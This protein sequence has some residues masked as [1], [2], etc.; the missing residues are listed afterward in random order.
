MT[1]RLANVGSS[2]VAVILVPANQIPERY[3]LRYLL[4]VLVLSYLL[5]I[6]A[7]SYAHCIHKLLFVWR[8][9][10]IATKTLGK[11]QRTLRKRK[12][13]S[14]SSP[15]DKRLNESFKP[16]PV[17][18]IEKENKYKQARIWSQIFLLAKIENLHLR[19]KGAKPLNVTHKLCLHC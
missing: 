18:F 2:V 3:I 5:W 19:I 4:H 7:S 1:V 15:S 14:R 17:S 6:Y 8:D 16:F 9:L 10:T 11:K 13:G 12:G